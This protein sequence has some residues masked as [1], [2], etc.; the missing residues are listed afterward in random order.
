MD[1][2]LKLSAF[3]RVNIAKQLDESYRI[4]VRRHN[5]EVSKNRRILARLIDCVKFCGVFELTLQGKDESE[6]SSNSGIFHGLVDLMALLNKVFEE[7]LKTATV[8]KGTS[9]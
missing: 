1:S 5:D 2:C 7:L 4:A 6:G 8:F 3:G 9:K